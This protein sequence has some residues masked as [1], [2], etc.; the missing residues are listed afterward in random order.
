MTA[1]LSAIQGLRDRTKHNN[2]NL[3]DPHGD[4]SSND[5][6]P[7][8]GE[9]YN[10]VINDVF[11]TVKLIETIQ[12]GR[13]WWTADTDVE[14]IDDIARLTN[15]G[16]SLTKVW[17]E[18][19]QVHYIFALD[20]AKAKAIL[21][22]EPESQEW[23][24]EDSQ[25]ESAPP[26]SLPTNVTPSDTPTFLTFSLEVKIDDEPQFRNRAYE[27]AIRDGLPPEDAA[28]YLDEDKQSVTQCAVMVFDRGLSPV[29]CSILGSSA[30]DTSNHLVTEH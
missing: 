20:R 23:M 19:E 5:S 30:E 3:N 4:G 14:F 8:S 18:G 9:D 12:I 13:L 28:E 17:R 6:R 29:G 25:D 24:I 22:Y 1:I 27:Q 16:A 21:G 15:A 10:E 7:P 11:H 2:D 26:E